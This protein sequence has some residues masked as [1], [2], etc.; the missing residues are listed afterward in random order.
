MTSINDA[1][2]LG[3]SSTVNKSLTIAIAATE[4]EQQPIACINLNTINWSIE[5]TNKQLT[6]AK[7]NSERPKYSG[8]FRPNLSNKGPYNNCPAEMPMKNVA[9]ESDTF[10]TSVFKSFAIAL[11]PGKYMSMEKGASAARQPRINMR[12]N[13]LDFAMIILE[14]AKMRNYDCLA[15][16]CFVK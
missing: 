6:D 16:L 8:F 7:I 11:N 14:G 12:K 2:T 5:V 9:K 10:G 4:A 15:G 3:L 13:D 1:K